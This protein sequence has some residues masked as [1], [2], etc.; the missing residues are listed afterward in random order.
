MVDEGE[1]ESEKGNLLNLSFDVCL[2]TMTVS[3][4]SPWLMLLPEIVLSFV[5]EDAP[6]EYGFARKMNIFVCLLR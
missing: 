2:A 4:L 1:L 3:K 6:T 5:L